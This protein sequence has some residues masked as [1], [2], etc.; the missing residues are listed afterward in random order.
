MLYNVVHN[1][2]YIEEK[3]IRNMKKKVLIVL[4]NKGNMQ[5]FN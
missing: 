5:F 1:I 2:F 3:K 4:C